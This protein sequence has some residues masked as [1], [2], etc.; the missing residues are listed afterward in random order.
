M[1]C[2]VTRPNEPQLPVSAASRAVRDAHLPLQR[3]FG[4]R[5][6]RQAWPA[7]VAS[8]IGLTAVIDQINE[9]GGICLDLL[10]D[11]WSPALTVQ[12]L[13]L[14]LLSLLNEPNP[15]DPLVPELAR[16]IKYDRK[17]FERTGACA[18]P[19]PARS[20]TVRCRSRSPPRQPASGR[21][22]T[23]LHERPALEARPSAVGSDRFA[24]GRR[25]SRRVLYV[26]ICGEDRG[27]TH[28]QSRQ[29][30]LATRGDTLQQRGDAG[31]APTAAPPRVSFTEWRG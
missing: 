24:G 22:P 3:A 8:S 1:S 16:Q 12:K 20:P 31:A 7:A 18:S 4:P 2:N 30:R 23:R 17:G 9:A 15:D 14:S 21:G 10:K 29:D 13:L 25:R 26:C 28:S 5:C 6:W 11:Q 19:L 27:G